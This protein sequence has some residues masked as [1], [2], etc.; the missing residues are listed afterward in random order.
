MAIQPRPRKRSL[1]DAITANDCGSLSRPHISGRPAHLSNEIGLLAERSGGH[2][3][4]WDVNMSQDRCAIFHRPK[5]TEVM[6]I[7][8]TSLRHRRIFVTHKG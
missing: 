3:P 2:A 6:I 7:S 5:L 4:G 1:Q 8:S